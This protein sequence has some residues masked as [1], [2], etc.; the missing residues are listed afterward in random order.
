MSNK[1]YWVQKSY[2]ISGRD[3]SIVLYV[4]NDIDSTAGNIDWFKPGQAKTYRLVAKNKNPECSTCIWQL[5]HTYS[6]LFRKG[7]QAYVV[8][9]EKDLHEVFTGMKESGSKVQLGV[10][11]K[12]L[13]AKAGGNNNKSYWT[14]E[15]AEW[16]VPA[17]YEGRGQ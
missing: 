9:S 6:G 12:E 15:N 8:A 1:F 7:L 2:Q 16:V 4:A 14:K 13:I 11:R 5:Q 3:Y 10:P 17:G